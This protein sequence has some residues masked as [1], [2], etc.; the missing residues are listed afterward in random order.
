MA[1]HRSIAAVAL[2]ALAALVPTPVPAATQVVVDALGSEPAEVD[3]AEDAGGSVLFRLDGS[4]YSAAAGAIRSAYVQ[5][6]TQGEP[7]IELAMAPAAGLNWTVALPVSTPD[8]VKGTW[9]VTF[10]GLRN[11][12][13]E[14]LGNRTLDVTAKDTAAPQLALAK[15]A[16]PVVL[17]PG[18]AVDLTVRDPLLRGVTFEF[19]GLPPLP[20]PAP[21]TFPGDGLPE[22]RTEVTFKASDRAGH[23]TTLKVDVVRDTLPPQLNVTVPEHVYSGVPFIVYAR[24]AE[25]GPYTLRFSVNG[26]AQPDV[27]VTGSVAPGVNRST[28]FTVTP[29]EV[30]VLSIGVQAIDQ[31]PFV[32]VGGHQVVVE[33]PITDLRMSRLGTSPAGPQFAQRPVV[34][35]A[36]LEQ[37]E[38]V[39]ALPVPVTLSVEGRSF[40][41]V[42]EVPAT[43]PRLLTWEVSLPGGRYSASAM[44]EVPEG[45]NETA[46]GDENATAEFEVF[47]GRVLHNGTAYDIRAG[48]HGLPE[49]A[50]EEGKDTSYPLEIVDSGKGVAYQFELPGN[51]TV[52]WDPLDPLGEKAAAGNATTTTSASGTT[53]GSKGAPAATPALAVLVVALAALAQRRRLR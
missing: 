51:R 47:L 32:A 49:S 25:A 43:G 37:V 12:G 9:E 26:T 19:G 23:A 30:G 29:G 35:T 5:L 24:V 44:A 4:N 21:Y 7:P 16:S 11:E 36:T 17:G 52:L 10:Y 28:A 33:T 39:T 46:P 22:G 38:G 6:T 20:L 27:Q 1:M 42:E 14:A 40:A 48:S 53:T 45:A 18:D 50:V 3:L 2:L 15:P 34:L 41:S 8:L 13:S 31:V